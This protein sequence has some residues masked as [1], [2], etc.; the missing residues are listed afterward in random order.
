M[1]PVRPAD[2]LVDQELVIAGTGY[3]ACSGVIV[4]RLDGTTCLQLWRVGGTVVRQEGEALQVAGWYQ[5]T[6][7]AG[8]PV[9]IQVNKRDGEQMTDEI[10]RRIHAFRNALALAADTRSH[11][12]FAMGRWQELNEFP[13]G[14]C[15]LA[16]NFLAQYLRDSE[17]TLQPVIIHMEATHSYRVDKESTVK[18]H[19]IVA[20][21]DK[22]IDL[23]L[24]QFAEYSRRV[25]I[26]DKYGTLASMQREIQRFGGT[27]TRRDINI[28][29]TVENGEELYDW[30]RNTA[31]RL[32]E[33][34]GLC[35]NNR[36]E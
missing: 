36:H 10:K 9:K 25:I 28:D 31:D 34:S 26:E 15:D 6:Y 11:E 30:L 32:L 8:L 12:C 27:V 13:H 2:N 7:D 24:N 21:G 1:L 19:V 3:T 17:P 18:S 23:T 22:Y 16:S 35:N 14:C 29:N 4:V 20:L 33:K 5:A